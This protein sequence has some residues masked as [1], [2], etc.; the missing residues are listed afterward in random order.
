MVMVELPCERRNGV[1]DVVWRSSRGV[2]KDV[3]VDV[4]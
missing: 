3:D 4:D 2:G 1:G